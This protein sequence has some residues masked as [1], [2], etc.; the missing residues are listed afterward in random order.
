MLSF[1]VGC[2]KTKVELLI[3]GLDCLFWTSS[4]FFVI[5]KSLLFKSSFLIIKL[6]AVSLSM[7]LSK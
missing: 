5:N 1:M 3:L 4:P 2:Y 7:R 6:K